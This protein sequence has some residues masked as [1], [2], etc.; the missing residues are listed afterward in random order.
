MQAGME[1]AIALTT[2]VRCGIHFILHA[3]GIL[4]S[5][6]A[7]SLEKFLIDEELCGMA[8]KMVRPVEITRDAIDVGTIEKV[9]IGGHYLAEPV[10]YERCRTAFFLPELANRKDYLTWSKAGRTRIDQRA[11]QALQARLASYRK[12][13]IDPGVERALADYVSRRKPGAPSA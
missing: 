11:S 1:S 10:T 4:G 9:G 5:Y 12:P 6:I 2:A 8:R 13:D 7:M 3:C